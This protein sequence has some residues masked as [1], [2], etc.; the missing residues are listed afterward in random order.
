MGT[1]AMQRSVFHVQ[2]SS[3]GRCHLIHQEIKRQIFDKRNRCRASGIADRA[4]AGWRGRLR[5][6]AAQVPLRHLLAV[7]YRL[8]ANGR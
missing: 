3:R 8:A 2:A 4:Y 5:S 1:E 6:A 7:T